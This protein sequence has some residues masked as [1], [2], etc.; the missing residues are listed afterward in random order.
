MNKERDTGRGKLNS[1]E[2]LKIIDTMKPYLGFNAIKDYPMGRIHQ[3]QE[4]FN[5]PYNRSSLT[6]GEDNINLEK[7]CNSEY[8]NILKQE[9]VSG[10]VERNFKTN[11]DPNYV[12]FE[13]EIGV[14]QDYPILKILRTAF[15]NFQNDHQD[16]NDPL[17]KEF[18]QYKKENPLVENYDRIALYPIVGKS[19]PDLFKN[20][21]DNPEKQKRFSELKIQ[22]ADEIEFFKFRQFLAFKQTLEA[23][24]NINARDVEIM[25]DIAI[26]STAE[27]YWA[28]PDAFDKNESIGYGLY[29]LKYEDINDKESEAY[30]FLKNKMQLGFMI[31]DALRLDV[32]V[33]YEKY[34]TFVREI[35]TWSKEKNQDTTT[36]IP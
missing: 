22:Y 1:D 31:Y 3:Y 17:R 4:H 34:D 16:A 7:L 28:F 6:L 23:K 18:E 5:C 19:E 11:N 15:D 30:K 14:N 12:N 13:N 21:K 26:G 35:G 33:S 32:G 29:K 24:E 27:E 9:D 20:F 2:A 8:G 10:V 36:R 25:G